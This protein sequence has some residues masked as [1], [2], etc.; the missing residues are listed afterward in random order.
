MTSAAQPET[1]LSKAPW[2]GGESKRALAAFA[3]RCH[4]HT[5]RPGAAK[6]EK[7]RGGGGG[8]GDG[9]SGGGGGGRGGG[10]NLSYNLGMVSNVKQ[11]KIGEVKKIN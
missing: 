6:K 9:G 11:F 7:R 10:M 1:S 8:G 4:H 3:A 5:G 2:K